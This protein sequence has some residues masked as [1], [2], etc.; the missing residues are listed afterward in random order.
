MP[1]I[2]WQYEDDD[3][4]EHVVNIPAQWEV[5]S[6]CHGKGTTY[7]G[8]TSAE[9][10]ALT[11]EDFDREG[12]DFMEEYVSGYYDRACPSCK[13]RTTVLVVDWDAFEA[14]DPELSKKYQRDLEDEAAY[15]R[16]VAMERRYGC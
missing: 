16:E 7:L 10:P 6:D 9:Q 14:T 2:K 12:P 5:C 1:T 13:G 3:G 4:E 11:R 8:W 15:Q